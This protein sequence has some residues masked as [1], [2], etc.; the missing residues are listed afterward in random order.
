MAQLPSQ[1]SRSPAKLRRH[2]TIQLLFPS[3]KQIILDTR[4]AL[5]T[6]ERGENFLCPKLF[7]SLK[8]FTFCQAWGVEA[9][10]EGWKAERSRGC[11]RRRGTPVLQGVPIR[12]SP[13]RSLFP[14][15]SCFSWGRKLRLQA[16]RVHGRPGRAAP[17]R[18]LVWQEPER[19]WGKFPPPCAAQQWKHE[20]LYSKASLWC[21]G[22]C[23][24]F[25]FFFSDYF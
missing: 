9:P 24:V 5:I 16:G 17:R 7:D 21:W 8:G 14:R 12:L 15:K 25:F 23:G 20:V 10:V 3:G 2:P 13:C 19:G 11:G 1:P 6:K 22:F 18:A 4:P